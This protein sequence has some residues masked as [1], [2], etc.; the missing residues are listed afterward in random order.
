[1]HGYRLLP[2]VQSLLTPGYTVD[3]ALEEAG[4]DAMRVWTRESVTAIRV[5]LLASWLTA[6]ASVAA[7]IAVFVM[8][9]GRRQAPRRRS[10]RRRTAPVAVAGAS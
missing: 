4:F 9:Q 2:E 3:Q 8:H 1:M 5:A 7:I 6:F 10:H